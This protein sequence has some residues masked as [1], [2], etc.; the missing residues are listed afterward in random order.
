MLQFLQNN[1]STI[2]AALI[3][4]LLVVLATRK[5][6]KDKKKGIGSCGC[7]CSE[8]PKAACC[9]EKEKEAG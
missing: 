1:L 4:I 3:V 7:K 8:C 6:V 5:M 2:I 9:E